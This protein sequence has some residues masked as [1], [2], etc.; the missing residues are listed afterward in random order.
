MLIGLYLDHMI[1]LAVGLGEC[2][3]EPWT[4]SEGVVVVTRKM[5]AVVVE[6]NG[7]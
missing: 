4:W 6:A 1:T 7:R 2:C 3:P 5:C